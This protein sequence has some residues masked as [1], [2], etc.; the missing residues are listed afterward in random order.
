L[1][2]KFSGDTVA[3]SRHEQAAIFRCFFAA[4][5][6]KRFDNFWLSTVSLKKVYASSSPIESCEKAFPPRNPRF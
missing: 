2:K 6:G 4:A 5:C 1:L 3:V